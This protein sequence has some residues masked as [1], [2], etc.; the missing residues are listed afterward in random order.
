MDSETARFWLS[1][2]S[3]KYLHTKIP[4]PV[5]SHNRNYPEHRLQVCDIVQRHVQQLTP[6]CK[7]PVGTACLKA[8]GRIGEYVP[9]TFTARAFTHDE[10]NDVKIY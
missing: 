6:L 1:Q 9:F 4:A 7:S 3:N 8:L 10:Q 2:P 5:H